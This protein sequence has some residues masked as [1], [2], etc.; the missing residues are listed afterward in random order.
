M[1]K[2]KVTTKGIFSHTYTSQA[3]SKQ[4][5]QEATGMVISNGIWSAVEKGKKGIVEDAWFILTIEKVKDVKN[6]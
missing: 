3:D 6:K 4:E 5:I 2:Y 1:Y